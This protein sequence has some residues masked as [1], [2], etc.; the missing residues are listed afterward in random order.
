MNDNFKLQ[1]VTRYSQLELL[2][3][4]TEYS[5]PVDKWFDDTPQDIE[6]WSKQWEHHNIIDNVVYCCFIKDISKHEC[7]LIIN[8]YI[9]QF[10]PQ[11]L[12]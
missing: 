11:D 6:T 3:Q 10:K 9:S 5:I 8:G 12:C 7:D 4:M 2:K 1:E